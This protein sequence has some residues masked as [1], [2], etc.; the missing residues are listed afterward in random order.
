RS[1]MSAALWSLDRVQEAHTAAADALSMLEG[2]GEGEELARAPA[3]FVRIEAIAFDPAK[4]IERGPA[5]LA[6]AAAAGLDEARIDTLISVALAHGHR[7]D[8]NA[9]G[10][11]EEARSEAQLAG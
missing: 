11:L 1:V 5:A 6:A 3:A 8:P 9:I 7:G 4:A 2:T 10:M